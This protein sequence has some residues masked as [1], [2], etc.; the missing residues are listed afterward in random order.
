MVYFNPTMQESSHMPNKEWGE[1][2]YLSPDFNSSTVEIY[3]WISNFIPH[4]IMDVITYPHW[5]LS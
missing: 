3:E 1:I 2:T 5:D 4:F